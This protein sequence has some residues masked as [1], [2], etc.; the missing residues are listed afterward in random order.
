[1]RKILKIAFIVV[2]LGG[3][4]ASCADDKGHYNY[5]WLSDVEMTFAQDSLVVSRG[6][7]LDV[8][9]LLA[10][11]GDGT[12]VEMKYDEYNYQWFGLPNGILDSVNRVDLGDKYNL[13]ER[14]WMEVLTAYHRVELRATHKE[15]GRFFTADFHVR[16]IGMYQDA[17]LFLTEDSAGKVELE[18]YGTAAD[19]SAAY[20][21]NYLAANGYPPLTGGANAVSYDGYFKRIYLSAGS[22][23]YWLNT[24][25]FSYNALS[26]NIGELLVPQTTD[27]FSAIR[28][29]GPNLT[30]PG[31][32]LIF[33]TPEGDVHIGYAGNV[34][35]SIA[36]IGQRSVQVAP[37]VAGYSSEEAHSVIML[38]NKTDNNLVYANMFNQ[39]SVAIAK[40]LTVLDPG[41][42]KPPTEAL[43]LGGSQDRTMI[44]VVKDA[45]AA[46][47]RLDY[48][49]YQPTSGAPF[50]PQAIHAPR[51][52]TGTKELG[53]ISHWFNSPEKGYL[54]AVVGN[55]LHTFVESQSGGGVEDPG[56][57]AVTIADKQGQAVQ[58]EDP[59]TLVYSEYNGAGDLHTSFYVVT[60]SA[61]KGGTVYM[62]TPAESGE[63]LVL[64]KK[65]TGLGNVKHMCYWWG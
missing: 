64:L 14:I 38:W 6:E 55:K 23:M 17:Y 36:L 46:Y 29:L 56:W 26:N 18:F 8:V 40:S 58:I 4:F 20:E 27:T 52:L 59:V 15:T 41:M 28:R 5:H 39:G 33:F 25:D 31:R 44:A 10:K 37:M 47:W 19:G 7:V 21:K 16:V 11:R 3:L 24:P 54:Y 61:S 13:N 45:D 22:G 63:K 50:M 65:I 42:A 53:N 9:P 43:Y 12:P 49:A 57:K 1:M 51:K 60:Y 35:I 34:S 62:L 2:C 48:R 32:M 30:M